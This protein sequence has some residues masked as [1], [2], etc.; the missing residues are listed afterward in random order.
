VLLVIALTGLAP[1]CRG[2]APPKAAA[3]P[4]PAQAPTPAP[5]PEESPKPPDEPAA[6]ALPEVTILLASGG[7]KK[8]AVEVVATPRG[9]Q[10]GLMHRTHLPEDQGMFFH[11]GR[12]GVQSFWMKNTLIP[13]DMLFID[14]AGEIVGIV[15]SAEPQTL[16]P[17]GVSRPSIYVLEVNGG[18]CNKHG[19]KT[20]DRMVMDEALAAAAAQAGGR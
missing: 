16:T 4:A 9:R 11:M 10:T 17:R 8:V 3:D 14:E 2:E 15:E 7:Q 13:L 12:T 1:A 6:E 18:W 19:V 20:G 5:A